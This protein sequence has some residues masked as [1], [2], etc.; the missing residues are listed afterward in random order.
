MSKQIDK[1]MRI[2]DLGYV[3]RFEDIEQILEH[4]LDYTVEEIS[5]IVPKKYQI[6]TLS[7]N[8]IQSLGNIEL[9]CNGAGYTNLLTLS[10]LLCTI[11]FFENTYRNS[12]IIILNYMKDLR[13]NVY[14]LNLPWAEL[15]MAIPVKRLT[16]FLNRKFCTDKYSEIYSN[17]CL[18]AKHYALYEITDFTTIGGI[19]TETSGYLF[20]S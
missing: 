3:D 19:L 10:D 13:N 17:I 20:A 11:K 12:H 2:S 8:I 7:N 6:Q 16:E 15:F 5:N 4:F 1:L 14:F 9:Q 18:L